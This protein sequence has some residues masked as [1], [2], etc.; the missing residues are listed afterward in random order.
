MADPDPAARRGLSELRPARRL[1]IDA[2]LDVTVDGR[3]VSLRGEGERLVVQV[4]DSATAFKLFQANRPGRHLVRTITDTLELF[5]IDVAVRVGDRTV[6]SLGPSADPGPVS[7]AVG[8]VVGAE[9]ID[10]AAPEIPANTRWV[11]IGLAFLAGA[12]LGARR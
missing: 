2:D 12:L 8:R 4:E 1:A 6:A 11:A 7:R 9:G 3:A 10:F 5:G